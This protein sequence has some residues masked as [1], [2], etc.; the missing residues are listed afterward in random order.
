M[1]NPAYVDETD[2]VTVT[3]TNQETPVDSINVIHAS[4]SLPNNLNDEQK[5][6]YEITSD[7]ING[8]NLSY[9]EN[10]YGSK[11]ILVDNDALNKNAVAD[12]DP[13]KTSKIDNDDDEIHTG[14]DTWGKDIEFLLS[15]IAMSVGLG[16]KKMRIN[17]IVLLHV[18]YDELYFFFYVMYFFK[19]NLWRFPFIALENGGGAFVIP[20]VIVLI[21]IGK[22]LYYLEMLIG[23]FSSRGSVKVYDLAPA[24]RGKCFFHLHF[25]TNQPSF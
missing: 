4:K 6:A 24:L 8:Q 14:R 19:G 25:S 9:N 2:S 22:P 21:I 7:K 12:L 23:Q 15:C 17:F 1:E 10:G 3:H 11:I 18:R 13:T 20:Y 16:N 5:L